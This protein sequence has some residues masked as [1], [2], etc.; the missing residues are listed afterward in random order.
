MGAD[1][2]VVVREGIEL[3][4]ELCKSS[5]RRLLCQVALERLMQA[6]DLALVWPLCNG[7]C[8]R[9]SQAARLST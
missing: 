8:L 7:P 6:L 1:G 4:L 9:E 5:R 3:L 2:V